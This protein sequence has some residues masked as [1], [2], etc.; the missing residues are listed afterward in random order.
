MLSAN[1][2]GEI[3]SCMLLGIKQVDKD[4]FASVKRGSIKKARPQQRNKSIV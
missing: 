2:H 4:Q 3:F 1:Q